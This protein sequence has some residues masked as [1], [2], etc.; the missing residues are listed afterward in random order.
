[1]HKLT[2]SS[3]SSGFR[4]SGSRQAELRKFIIERDSK[5]CVFTDKPLTADNTRQLHACHIL[6]AAKSKRV[7]HRDF[8]PWFEKEH[9][10]KYDQHHHYVLRRTA[11]TEGEEKD[12]I[13]SVNSRC[14]QG[15]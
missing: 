10:A 7:L 2:P 13:R 4:V 14:C 11:D 12:T 3:P 6:P 15:G 9:S 5:R 8:V 1:M